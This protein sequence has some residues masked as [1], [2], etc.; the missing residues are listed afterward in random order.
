MAAVDEH[1]LS[2]WGLLCLGALIPAARGGVSEWALLAATGAALALVILPVVLGIRSGSLALAASSLDPWAAAALLWALAACFFPQASPDALVSF[3]PLLG[4]VAVFLAARRLARAGRFVLELPIALSAIAS[5]FVI[6]AVAQLLGLLPNSWWRP[7]EF[8]AA[9]FV[10]HNHFAVYLAVLLPVAVSLRLSAPLLSWQR[11]VLSVSCALL[12]LGIV[13]SCSRGVWL[14]LLGSSVLAGLFAMRA[15]GVSMWT[16]RR[17]MLL[18][19]IGAGAIYMGSQ[20]AVQARALSFLSVSE[21]LSVAQRVDMWEGTRNLVR[22]NPLFGQGFAGFLLAFPRHRPPGLY[23]LVNFAHNDYLQ[24]VADVG[25]V[26]LALA[27]VAAVALFLRVMCLAHLA[28]T[29]WKRAL[30]LG[31]FAGLAAVALHGLVDLPWHIPAVTFQVAALAGLASGVSYRADPAPMRKLAIP[32]RLSAGLA[33]RASVATAGFLVLALAVPAFA[34]L[35]ASEVSSAQGRAYREGGRYE[36]AA[37]AY[38]RAVRLAPYLWEAHRGL[39]QSLTGRAVRERGA[40]LRP[41]L[42]EAARVW[43]R[44]LAQAPADSFGAHELALAYGQL[45]RVRHARRWADRALAGDPNNPMYWKTRGDL[46]LRAG[47]A[48]EAADAFRRAAGLAIPFGFFPS[49]F[50]PLDRPETYLAMG[51][52]ARLSRRLAL[53]EAAFRVARELDAGNPQAHVGL[54]VTALARGDE[55]TAQEL[56]AYVREPQ[57][58]AVYFSE[59][60]R[61]ALAQGRPGEARQ[62]IAE[63]LALD[64]A[65]VLARHLDVSLA[66]AGGADQG[67]ED[68]VRALVDLNQSPVLLGSERAQ[69]GSLVW[70]PELAQYPRG[71]RISRGWGLFGRGSLAQ[72]IFLPPGRVQF[73]VTALGTEVQG[74]GPDMAVSWN[75]KRILTAE[76][77]GEAWATFAIETVVRPGESVLSID[78][79]NDARD[80]VSREDRN[81]KIDKIV[82]TWEP[83]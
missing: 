46:A 1:K 4:L 43:R 39:A 17:L 47:E 74:R 44:V 48:W 76:V 45:E 80:P 5:F 24:L 69:G 54:A 41:A 19:L 21:D 75:G 59:R 16:V 2:F 50:A 35:L 57:L 70:E 71:E 78:F 3:F 29:P 36:E 15:G 68:S 62:H 53:A 22:E 51:E 52:A 67:Y 38:R 18:A 13:L 82:A 23:Q 10:N 64:P 73:Q 55:R 37:R 81:L 40:R 14:S 32:L 65:N 79:L 42:R 26:G 25:V 49:V 8:A 63:S 56:A 11:F 60:A 31:T 58:R 77:R 7:R 6:V 61:L 9:T 34:S 20:P 72:Q 33:A 66:Q 30:A 12:A 27:A 83:I 28:R